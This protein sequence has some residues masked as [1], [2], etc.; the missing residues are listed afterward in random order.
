MTTISINREVEVQCDCSGCSCHVSP[1][2]QHCEA[3]H[4]Q[5]V[6][7]EVAVDCSYTPAGESIYSH[8]H[9]NY[10]PGKDAQFDWD[11]TSFMINDRPATVDE[12][13][14]IESDESLMLLF[15][16]KIRNDYSS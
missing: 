4:N 2:C 16:E 5:T 10:L 8:S 1:P 12:I 9:G 14:E 3:G 13:E 11:S 7:Q 15:E 6:E